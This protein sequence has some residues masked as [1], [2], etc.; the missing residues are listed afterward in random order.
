MDMYGNSMD[1]GLVIYL[2]KEVNEI[3]S[4]EEMF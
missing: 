1:L 4:D 3:I 2:I